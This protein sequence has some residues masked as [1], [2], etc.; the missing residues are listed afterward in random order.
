MR[1]RPK[2]WTWIERLPVAPVTTF[3]YTRWEMIVDDGSYDESHEVIQFL[4]HEADK[5]RALRK[6]TFRMKKTS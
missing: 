1:S 2:R 5:L 4:R 6:V 3:D